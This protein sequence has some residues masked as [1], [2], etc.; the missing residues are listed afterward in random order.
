MFNVARYGLGTRVRV[1][2]GSWYDPVADLARGA[3]GIVSNPPY[4]RRGD[5]RGLQLEARPQDTNHDSTLVTCCRR[6][7]LSESWL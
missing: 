3:A 6:G 1:L 5:L 2:M 7:A 4:I